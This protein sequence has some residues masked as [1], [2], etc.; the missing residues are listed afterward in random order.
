MEQIKRIKQ[1]AE[2]ILLM[3]ERFQNTG[4]SEIEKDIV[5]AELRELY[6]EIMLTQA[7]NHINNTEIKS[8][9]PEKEEILNP[10]NISHDSNNTVEAEKESEPI[11]ETESNS[12]EDEIEFAAEVS[13]TENLTTSEVKI[14]ETLPKTQTISQ[15]STDKGVSK[16][17]TSPKV[18]GDQ[19]RTKKTSLNERY[20]RAGND[21]S[22]RINLSPLDN[23]KS[24]IGVGDR[25]LYIKELFSSD[26]ELYESTINTLNNLNSMDEALNHIDSNFNW[27]PDSATVHTFLT[28]VKRKFL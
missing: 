16:N 26:N 22:S 27:D 2:E 1:K 28:L 8:T 23:I 24:G 13:E 14:K 25:F 7:D 6:K 9:E 3:T 10:E 4:I 11:T 5:L 18:L 21:I 15:T 20:S 12:K 19:L 17:G